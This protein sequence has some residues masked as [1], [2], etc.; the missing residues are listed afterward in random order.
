LE[1]LEPEPGAAEA[2]AARF[3]ATGDSPSCSIGTAQLGELQGGIRLEDTATL[4]VLPASRQR[5]FHYGTAELTRL[6]TGAAAAV[7]TE[8]P[9]S[10]LEV[11]NLSREGG[12]DIPPSVS[13]NS[14]RDVDV[15]FYA[16]DRAH[17]RDASPGIL[18]FGDNGVSDY[19][20]AA[21][22]WEFDTARNWAFVRHLLGDPQVVVQWIFVSVPLRNRLLDYALRQGEPESLRRRAQQVLVQPRDA[23]PH[24]DHFHVRIACPDGDRPACIDGLG[25]Q[26]QARAAQVDALL[27]M[28]AHGSPAEQRYARELL[29][30]PPDGDAAELPP[31]EGND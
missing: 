11:G 1:P 4:K 22:K 21:G 6:L 8:F 5:G 29:T 23:S 12:G 18:H 31:I 30:L 9:G 13:H 14:G 28:Y 17:G 19:G 2:T 25:L 10:V 27:E 20:A 3:G 24:A 26:P 7:A 15:S 16:F